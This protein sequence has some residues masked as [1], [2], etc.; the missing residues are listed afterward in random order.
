MNKEE[1]GFIPDQ[2]RG[3]LV[4]IERDLSS[5]AITVWTVDRLKGIETR[6]DVLKDRQSRTI[7]HTKDN[8]VYEIERGDIGVQN[9]I[10]VTVDPKTRFSRDAYLQTVLFNREKEH[11]IC[12]AV[13][14]D[15]SVGGK[16]SSVA[17][18]VVP[19]TA[20]ADEYRYLEGDEKSVFFNKR[21]FEEN[22]IEIVKI[23]R[24]RGE[25][26]FLRDNYHEDRSED[27]QARV[28]L[29][30]TN[31]K[32]AILQKLKG[33]N[34]EEIRQNM[35]V[36]DIEKV[37]KRRVYECLIGTLRYKDIRGIFSYLLANASRELIDNFEFFV[38]NGNLAVEK[39]IKKA[40]AQ[41]LTYYYDNV[42]KVGQ[43][44]MQFVFDKKDSNRFQAE[45]GLVDGERLEGRVGE[46][47]SNGEYELKFIYSENAC[48]ISVKRLIGPKETIFITVPRH[49]D[50]EELGDQI[51]QDQRWPTVI[52]ALNLDYS[53]VQ[54]QE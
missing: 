13:G 25:E 8:I 54:P 44:L 34:F 45:T 4:N 21:T 2:T 14:Y 52:K 41:S 17:L 48:I 40:A 24:L 38:E 36:D 46:G 12:I 9:H 51:S 39:A 31:A 42:G 20:S 11:P 33:S 10:L 28:E 35:I 32:D 50:I 19:K 26:T 18:K 53:L 49:V 3:T 47:F 22:M 7:T 5:G 30:V 29:V 27:Q 43:S 23:W 6:V 16:I 15:S 1:T 37:V